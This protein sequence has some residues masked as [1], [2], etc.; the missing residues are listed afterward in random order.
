[1]VKTGRV[2]WKATGSQCWKTTVEGAD[3]VLTAWRGELLEPYATYQI[4]AKIKA[5]ATGAGQYVLIHTLPNG[6]SKL[7][8]GVEVRDTYTRVPQGKGNISVVIQNMTLNPVFVPKGTTLAH[9]TE[10]QVMPKPNVTEEVL[11]KLEE[12]DAQEGSKVLTLTHPERVQKLLED[13]DL[14]GL[15]SHDA[16]ERQQAYE[17]FEE[18]QDVY[19][20]ESQ[21][22]LGAVTWRNTESDSIRTSPSRRDIALLTHA[23]RKK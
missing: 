2:E 13:L 1:M 10:A 11:K 15:D 8:I 6:E 12:I 19:A 18:Y 14:Q 9:L 23:T 16:E 4:G 21:E 22:R 3:K 17:L 7:P 5:R 20:M